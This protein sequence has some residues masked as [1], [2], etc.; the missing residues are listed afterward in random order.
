VFL[1][2]NVVGGTSTSTDYYVHDAMFGVRGGITNQ[3]EFG[4]Y[5]LR[6]ACAAGQASLAF[7]PQ[8]VWMNGLDLENATHPVNLTDFTDVRIDNSFIAGVDLV[9]VDHDIFA[10]LQ[11]YGYVPGG[12]GQFW[13]T[14]SYVWAAAGS[15]VWIDVRDTQIRG[16]DIHICNGGNFGGAAGVEYHS[17]N[18]HHLADNTF[19]NVLGAVGVAS[20]QGYAIDAAASAVSAS[21]NFYYGCA[22][23][24]TDNNQSGLNFEVNANPAPGPP[25]ISIG[26]A[27]SGVGTGSVALFQGT[28]RGGTILLTAGTGSAALGSVILSFHQ[29]IFPAPQCNVAFGRGSGVWDAKVSWN[30]GGIGLTA[31]SYEIDW[32]NNGVVLA[33]GAGYFI[34][35]ECTQRGRG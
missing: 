24:M 29:A 33:P 10:G 11:N 25:I 28:D 16:N 22:A 4:L 30:N 31:S 15:C 1:R 35:Y 32:F 5:G 2:G 18:T 7:C 26:S 21:N 13:L 17:G 3:A 14:N 12:G 23:E 9:N 34:H 27:G 19:C 8:H 6:V 20:P